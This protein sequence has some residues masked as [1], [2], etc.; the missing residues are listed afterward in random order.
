MYLDWQN[1]ATGVGGTYAF[2]KG[3][4][5]AWEKEC[6]LAG[7]GMSP[8]FRYL[9]YTVSILL[10]S[11]IELDFSV[12]IVR[13]KRRV[14]KG[15]TGKLGSLGQ[16]VSVPLFWSSVSFD[17]LYVH[18]SLSSFPASSLDDMSNLKQLLLSLIG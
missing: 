17:P 12:F 2:K 14:Y 13:D 11:V 16:V 3:W 4:E 7:L 8:K 18:S 6:D 5:G 15:I 10:R 1:G 9:Y